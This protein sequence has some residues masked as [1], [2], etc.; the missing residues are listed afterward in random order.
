MPGRWP[1]RPAII[2]SGLT[3]FRIPIRTLGDAKAFT[4]S[5]GQLPN[6]FAFEVNSRAVV[7]IGYFLQADVEVQ[8]RPD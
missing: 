4:G 2:K 5:L 6:V 1:S 8:R 3:A 7:S